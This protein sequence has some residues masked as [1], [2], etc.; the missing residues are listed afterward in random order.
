[1]DWGCHEYPAFPDKSTALT[2]AEKQSTAIGQ[3]TD[4]SLLVPDG[5]ESSFQDS[6]PLVVLM[7]VDPDPLFPLFPT[8]TH[9]SNVEHEMPVM[10]TALPGGVWLVH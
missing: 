6:P 10:F 8:P 9:S 2:P 7:I 5:T 3:E 1:M 4:V